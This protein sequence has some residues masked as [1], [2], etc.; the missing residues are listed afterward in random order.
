MS[1]K[2]CIRTPNLRISTYIHVPSHKGIHRCMYTHAC[3]YTYINM[4][5]HTYIH[6]YILTYL[7]TYI[8]TYLPVLAVV[9]V[10]SLCPGDSPP[11][12]K[13]ASLGHL[14]VLIPAP[15]RARNPTE[16][17][18]GT[19]LGYAASS[20][21]VVSKQHANPVALTGYLGG[22]ENILEK[23]AGWKA[24]RSSC[25]KRYTSEISGAWN[26]GTTQSMSR[27]LCHEQA[28]PCTN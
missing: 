9:R 2:Y 14:L 16:T 23:V 19:D 24:V 7:H 4:Y 8:H 3:I 22:V 21:Q 13:E 1:I 17:Q 20:Q 26:P 11:C 5:I 12:F 27:S 25:W 28:H 15:P 6:T 10:H 18:A